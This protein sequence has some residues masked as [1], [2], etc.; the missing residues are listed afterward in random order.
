VRRTHEES[1]ALFND[2]EMAAYADAVDLALR[3]AIDM[4]QAVLIFDDKQ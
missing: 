1:P 2:E 4:L 3:R